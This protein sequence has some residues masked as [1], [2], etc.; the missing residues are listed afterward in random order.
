M[1]TTGYWVIA[2]VLG[3]V[4]AVV[5]VVLLQMF[6]REVRRI[7][8]AAGEIWQAGQQVASN[9]SATWLLQETSERLD[10]LNAE[11]QRHQALLGGNGAPGG[12]R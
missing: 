2:L 12:A 8:A 9:T 7:E 6:Y 1:S 11:A 10:G 3:L 5:A 4:V